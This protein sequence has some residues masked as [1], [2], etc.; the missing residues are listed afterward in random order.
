MKVGPRLR[1]RA[2]RIGA[3]DDWH[4]KLSRWCVTAAPHRAAAT[5]AFRSPR[6]SSAAVSGAVARRWK[7]SKVASS[8]VCRSAISRSTRSIAGCVTGTVANGARRTRSW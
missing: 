6:K 1:F 7:K 2:Q 5:N 8:T 3:G 4:S